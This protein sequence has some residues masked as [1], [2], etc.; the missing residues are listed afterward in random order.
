L[1]Q[2]FIKAEKAVNEALHGLWNKQFTDFKK[3]AHLQP[4]EKL[5][6]E[7]IG[8]LH[9][10][11]K[12]FHRIDIDYT[13]SLT[14]EEKTRMINNNELNRNIAE[15]EKKLDPKYFIREKYL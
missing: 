6:I 11:K 2:D 1:H 5:V 10:K 14:E 13:A 8:I 12:L 9:G 4:Y 3:K 7:G 15:E